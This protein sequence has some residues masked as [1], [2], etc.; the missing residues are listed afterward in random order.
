MSGE[1]CWQ[2]S[3]GTIFILAWQV[4]AS[5][6]Q[7]HDLEPSCD[8]MSESD[9]GDNFDEEASAYDGCLKPV[10]EVRNALVQYTASFPELQCSE[11]YASNELEKDDKP[12]WSYKD[13]PFHTNYFKFV[14]VLVPGQPL[15]APLAYQSGGMCSLFGSCLWPD[16]S[17]RMKELWKQVVLKPVPW[18]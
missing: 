15:S 2:P 14:E 9:S 1:R 8:E 11:R 10:A 4:L 18:R 12:H 7:N 3:S 16:G 5:K 13:E 17:P 6:L